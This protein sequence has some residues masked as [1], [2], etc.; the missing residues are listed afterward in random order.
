MK[1]KNLLPLLLA[2]ALVW[3]NQILTA[4]MGVL[5]ES[6]GPF[7][8]LASSITVL[9]P[10]GGE[11]WNGGTIHNITW[12]S[13]G[14]F[15][16]VNIDYSINN[17]S[18]WSSVAA[19]TANDGAY[20]WTVPA[21]IS[22]N[23]LVRIRDAVDSDPSDSSNRIFSISSAETETVSIPIQPLGSASGF[24]YTSYSFSTGGSTSNLGHTV[25]YRFDWGDGTTSNWLAAGT[26]MASHAWALNGTY[27][28][29]AM[30]RCATHTTIESLW[31]NALSIVISGAYKVSCD[32]NGDGKNDIVWWNIATGR[33]ICWYMDGVTRI[34]SVYLPTQADLDWKLSN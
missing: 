1:R 31:S 11:N 27:N 26:V 2:F 29:R 30:A 20:A 22:P 15:A 19:N 3:F 10:N 17:G 32:F 34:D 16:N 5:D 24:K 33:N 21:T 8:I 4:Q 25:Q 12:S 6:D 13:A 14:T 7:T 9:T 28:V 23:C 18:S